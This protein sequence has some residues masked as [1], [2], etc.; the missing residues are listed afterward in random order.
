MAALFSYLRYKG[1]VKTQRELADKL[2]ASYSNISSAMKGEERA[3]TN[4]LLKRINRAFH[5]MFSEDW[6]INGEGDML[7]QQEEQE[8]I[9]ISNDNNMNRHDRMRTVYEYL[10]RNG[11]IRTQKDLAEKVSAAQPTISGAMRGSE[12]CLTDNLF[13]RINAAFG[14][15][16]NERWLLTGEGE[17]L[18]EGHTTIGSQTQLGIVNNITNGHVGAASSP[19]PQA[20]ATTE[21]PMPNQTNDAVLLDV[22]SRQTDVIS[23]LTRELANVRMQLEQQSAKMREMESALGCLAAHARG[24]HSTDIASEDTERMRDDEH[25]SVG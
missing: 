18:A 5:G 24:V 17:M 25:K 10:R 19:L 3:C 13:R 15:I 9:I 4:N 2:G 12:M 16:F 6:L 14:Y 11:L 20:G 8:Q 23:S 7:A 22:I 21:M 1:L